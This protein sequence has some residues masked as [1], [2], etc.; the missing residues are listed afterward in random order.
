MII[1]LTAFA[2]ITAVLTIRAQYV[3]HAQKQ[4]YLFKPLTTLLIIGVALLG[5][6]ET[7]STYKTL[8]IIGMIFCLGG[9]I[10]LMLPEKYFI[11]GLG[12]FLIGH[13]F[14][15]AAFASDTAMALSFWLLPLAIYG[16]IVYA[17]LY[18][19]LGKMRWPVLVYVMTI[20]LMAYMALTRWTEMGTLGSLLA[21]MGALFFVLSDMVLAL[22][23]F[24]R[25]F[26]HARWITLAT[27]WLAQWLIA[28][29][30]GAHVLIF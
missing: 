7:T 29:S 18:K 21:A 20:M 1:F 12:S 14:Y 9:D 22:N 3:Q 26:T 24:K 27:Y 25:P 28:L 6:G 13:L 5:T 23:K 19:Y 4:E 8:I 15:V 10:F 17:I 2:F 30:V 16:A 11:A